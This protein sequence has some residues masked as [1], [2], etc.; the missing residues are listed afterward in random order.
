MSPTPQAAGPYSE[1]IPAEPRLGDFSNKHRGYDEIIDHL[2]INFVQPLYFVSEEQITNTMASNK[3][4]IRIGYVP[5]KYCTTIYR[6][7][8]ATRSGKRQ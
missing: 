4:T 6:A 1:R 7:C 2:F 5:G 3:P 8:S